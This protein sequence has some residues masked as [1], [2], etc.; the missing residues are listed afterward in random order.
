M[1]RCTQQRAALGKSAERFSVSEALELLL[2]RTQFKERDRLGSIGVLVVDSMVSCG[3]F[4]CGEAS[5]QLD[6]FDRLGS[7]GLTVVL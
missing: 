7:I 5:C 6:E 1:C 3:D 4:L 2:T